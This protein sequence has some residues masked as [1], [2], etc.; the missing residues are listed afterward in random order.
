MVACALNALLAVPAVNG[1]LFSRY[2]IY[3]KAPVSGAFFWTEI[4]HPNGQNNR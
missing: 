1:S 2:Q 3:F 4:R